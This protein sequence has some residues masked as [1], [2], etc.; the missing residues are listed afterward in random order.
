MGIMRDSY[1][2]HALDGIEKL[3]V[4]GRSTAYVTI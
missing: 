3:S 2:E 1:L 4:F